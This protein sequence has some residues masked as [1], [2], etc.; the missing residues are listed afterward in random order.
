MGLI[1]GFGL[2]GRRKGQVWT[3]HYIDKVRITIITSWSTVI[4]SSS[5]YGLSVD[6]CICR[7]RASW[8]INTDNGYMRV[9]PEKLVASV[10]DKV[11]ISASAP[12]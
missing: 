7:A 8:W 11:E 6:V 5:V 4:R 2:R 1:I 9:G 10:G 3:Q 12:T